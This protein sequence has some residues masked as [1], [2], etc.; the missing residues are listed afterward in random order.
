MNRFRSGTLVAL[1]VLALGCGGGKENEV[2]GDAFE[3]G[4]LIPITGTNGEYGVGFRKALELAA[5]EIN[6]SGLLLGKK[7]EI[8]V[9]DYKSD[10]TLAPGGAQA[11]IARGVAVIIGAAE[12]S[13]T[14]EAA[15]K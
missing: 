13:S 15:T 3:I 8:V 10:K 1:L 6:T 11:L 12:S 9:E 2:G 7:V 14:I 5:D 4:A